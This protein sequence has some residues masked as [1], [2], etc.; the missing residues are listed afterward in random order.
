MPMIKQDMPASALQPV[1]KYPLKI[2]IADE[3]AKSTLD[4]QQEGK[5]EGISIAVRA[6]ST[7]NRFVITERRLCSKK[8]TGP[9]KASRRKHARGRFWR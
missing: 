5:Y 1:H 7:W 6:D 8:A 9:A 4:N 2:F 3:A